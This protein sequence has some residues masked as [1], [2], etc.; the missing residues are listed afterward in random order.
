MSEPKTQAIPTIDHKPHKA[1]FRQ[2]GWL[3]IAAVVGGGLTWLVHLL[4]KAKSVDETQYAAFGTLL[5]LVMTCVPTM[6]LQMI[7]AQQTAQ[8]LANGRERQLSGII[9]LARWWTPPN[10]SAA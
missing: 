4:A 7:F 10:A 6:P 2:S 3:V 9:R 8:A 5:T 1:F